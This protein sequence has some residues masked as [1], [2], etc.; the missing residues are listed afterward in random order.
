[1]KKQI[2]KN[3]KTEKLIKKKINK[4]SVKWKGYNNSFKKDI[5]N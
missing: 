4:L 1:M 5:V 3:L 2:K